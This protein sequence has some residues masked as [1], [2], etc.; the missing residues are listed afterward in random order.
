MSN[1]FPNYSQNERL[2]NPFHASHLTN[3]K[4]NEKLEKMKEQVDEGPTATCSI[5]KKVT[6]SKETMLYNGRIVCK[7]CINNIFD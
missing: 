2:S 4:M 7:T 6:P 1:Q 3:Y 5:C